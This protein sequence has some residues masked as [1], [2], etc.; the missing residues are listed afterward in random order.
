[1]YGMKHCTSDTFLYSSSISILVRKTNF[2]SGFF[3]HAWCANP[4]ADK[5]YARSSLCIS[6]HIPRKLSNT[7]DNITTLYHFTNVNHDTV[8]DFVF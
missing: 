3:S 5:K 8:I 1:M 7:S 2:T 6:M 4:D